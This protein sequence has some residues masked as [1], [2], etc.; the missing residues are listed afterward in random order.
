LG[1]GRDL[2]AKIEGVLGDESLRGRMAAAARAGAVSR[3]RQS[4]LWEKI[5]LV[6]RKA[7]S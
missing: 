4:D 3:Y 6:M 7:R 1:D 5:D 2:A